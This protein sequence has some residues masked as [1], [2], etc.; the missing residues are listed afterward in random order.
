MRIAFVTIEYPPNLIGGAGAYA[1]ELCARLGARGHEVVVF[2]PLDI[3]SP[4]PST[5]RGVKICPIK[6]S[7]LLPQSI[8]FWLHLRTAIRE[9]GPFDIIHINSFPFYFLNQTKLADCPQVLTVH[10]LVSDAQECNHVSQ[11]RRLMDLR[12][13]N[14]IILPYLERSCIRTSN[15]IIGV[16]KYT[17]ERIRQRFDLPSDQV[18]CIPPGVPSL[19]DKTLISERSLRDR[20]SI[21]EGPI[22]LFV[23]RLNDPRK[24]FDVMMKAMASVTGATL[25]AVG[26]GDESPILSLAREYAVED[27]L[28]LTGFQDETTLASLYAISTICVVPSRLEG[29]G[30]TA[31]QSM[32]A[33]RPLLA[34]AVGA[35]PE[36]VPAEEL[37]PVGDA[38]ALS[39]RLNELLA[40]PAERS[41]LS[42]LNLVWAKQLMTFEEVAE[43][44]ESL[45]ES[46]IQQSRR[47]E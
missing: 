3:N 45:F 41:R 16:S 5:T 20:F 24:G 37:F 12:G 33:G 36:I 22:V 32:Q 10:H 43:R 6:T 21:T 42:D 35:L 44:T 23:G 1:G 18:V 47:G 46:L 4:H 7:P 19:C 27:R 29:Y 15:S 2:A 25:V 8:Q 14:A 38:E 30:Y 28:V 11:L 17:V 39:V 26:K 34:S 13:E 31:V 9:E 40:S